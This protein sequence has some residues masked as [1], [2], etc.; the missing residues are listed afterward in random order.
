MPGAQI[1]PLRSV[2]KRNAAAALGTVL[3]RH[4]ARARQLLA[5]AGAKLSG[6]IKARSGRPLLPHDD[7]AV[8]RN[9]ILDPQLP[10]P[11]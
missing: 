1:V 9:Q 4:H 5:R 2:G 3:Q 6:N 7:R 11:H 10:N 8:I